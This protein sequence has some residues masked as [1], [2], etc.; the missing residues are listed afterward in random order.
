MAVSK[1]YKALK[2]KDITVDCIAN[3]WQTFVVPHDMR[4]LVSITSEGEMSW[5]LW[6]F[7]ADYNVVFLRVYT[8]GTD[9]KI[10][11]TAGPYTIRVFYTD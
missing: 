10:I 11:D 7:R 5:V 1:I 6:R 2:Y 9:L 4:N 3:T 8:E